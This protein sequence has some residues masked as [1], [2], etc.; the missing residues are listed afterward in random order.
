[1]RLPKTWK[2]T[3]PGRYLHL[4]TGVEIHR[5]GRSW[6]IVVPCKHTCTP[7]TPAG[8]TRR[9]LGDVVV[10]AVDEWIPVMRQQIAAVWDDA[11]FA[12]VGRPHEW[13]LGRATKYTVVARRAAVAATGTP[14]GAEAKPGD[15]VVDI[16]TGQPGV[17]ESR[18]FISRTE[19]RALCFVRFAG[20]TEPV[21]V[22]SSTVVV[23]TRDW[24][25]CNQWSDEPGH[26]DHGSAV[27]GEC[28][29]P[30]RDQ[31]LVGP[32]LKWVSPGRWVAADGV[33]LF[34]GRGG[35]FAAFAPGPYGHTNICSGQPRKTRTYRMINSWRADLPRQ[36]EEAHQA[37]LDI[38]ATRAAIDVAQL[39]LARA[40]VAYNAAVDARLP[41]NYE[42][43]QV[44]KIRERLARAQLKLAHLEGRPFGYTRI[45]ISERREGTTWKPLFTSLSEAKA[46]EDPAEHAERYAAEAFFRGRAYRIRIYS[47][48]DA[49]TPDAEWTNVPDQP[50]RPGQHT[51]ADMVMP[52]ARRSDGS[53]IE[54]ATCGTCI[55]P[56]W[57]VTPFDGE[58]YPWLLEGEELPPLAPGV[59]YLSLAQITTKHYGMQINDGLGGWHLL[60][61]VGGFDPASGDIPVTVDD[62]TVPLPGG[63]MVQL[64]PAPTA[65][66][67]PGL[68]EDYPDPTRPPTQTP[69][70]TAADD[71]P[72][73]EGR[74]GP[75][76]VGEIRYRVQ[77]QTRPG[78]S[79]RIIQ[80][81][82][83]PTDLQA[84]LDVVAQ[85][86][87][88]NARPILGLRPK[89]TLPG[90]LVQ[91]W[92]WPTGQ[93]AT[94]TELIPDLF[95]RNTPTP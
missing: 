27:T 90:L 67:D 50:C 84:D 93:T 51:R 22:Y 1:M 32:P 42:A 29:L 10:L 81:G 94:A 75:V 70:P 71:D 52:G 4:E 33:E 44:Q 31:D 74:S 46:C 8:A 2:N 68:D 28:L 73:I 30:E 20:E 9:T 63:T 38:V 82:V 41:G 91:T 55:E 72:I 62:V 26:E 77:T 80:T 15:L 23:L 17:F 76:G 40:D 60:R 36:V 19:I 58:P 65:P 6:N 85:T 89:Q 49:T 12:Q 25:P 21:K 47:D 69:D 35:T 37:A 61:G 24:L 57:R 45:V 39:D 78:D 66:A 34:A 59:I 5:D 54:A 43:G 11:H 18:A 86:V 16:E 56:L 79:W 7:I 48:P 88:S 14:T 3:A 83:A 13:K 87:L 53:L 92:R 95:E 64:R